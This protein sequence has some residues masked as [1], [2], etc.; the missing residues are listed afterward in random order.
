M[1]AGGGSAPVIQSDMGA[2]SSVFDCLIA[3]ALQAWGFSFVMDCIEGETQSR[4]PDTWVRR[5]GHD[6]STVSYSHGE[7][8]APTT[9]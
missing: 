4:K 9:E 1:C 3:D 5:K 2:S 7:A 6:I 8:E